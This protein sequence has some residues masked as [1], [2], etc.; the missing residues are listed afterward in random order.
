[1]RPLWDQIKE[2]TFDITHSK[3]VEIEKELDPGDRRLSPSDFG[4]HNII[5]IS[6]WMLKF[7]HFE[8]AGWDDP[9]KMVCDFFLSA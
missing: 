9:A 3:H 4:F 8:Y 6:D 2:R 1:L 7:I 5:V